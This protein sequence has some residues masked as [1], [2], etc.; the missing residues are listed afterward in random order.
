MSALRTPDPD[1]APAF[2]GAVFGWQAEPFGPA[3]MWRLPGY[4]GGEP[5]QPVPRDVVAAMEPAQPDAAPEWAVDFCVADADTTAR[6]AAARG[7]RVLVA[8]HDTDIGGMLALMAEFESDL[9][10]ARTKEAMAIA[11]AEGRLKGKQPR[12][13]VLQRKRL[14]ADYDS[15]AYSSAE[16]MEISGLSRSA[17]YATLA[18]ARTE[19]T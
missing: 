15:G 16:L 7:G 2:Y 8:P 18:R 3:T 1:A 14:L 10:R 6:T 12:L 9:I 11:K 19:Q 13:S 5:Q 4:V 17:M